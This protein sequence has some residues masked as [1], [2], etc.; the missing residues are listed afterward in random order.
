MVG[1]ES[2]ETPSGELRMLSAADTDFQKILVFV[3]GI[4]WLAVPIS[5]AASLGSTGGLLWVLII[6]VPV[7]GLLV[8][9][10][11]R[12][13]V[14]ET[15]GRSLFVSTFFETMTLPLTL[16]ESVESGW[17][18]RY[19]YVAFR[20]PTPFGSEVVFRAQAA[21]GFFPN[22]QEIGDELRALVARARRGPVP[23]SVFRDRDA[24]PGSGTS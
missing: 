19:V 10:Q 17:M 7:V 6:G 11:F 14:V 15:D 4:T 5:V 16:I 1:S 13:M 18:S 20:Q 21:W 3:L 2:P 22:G 24:Q 23:G 12:L 9:G 8:W